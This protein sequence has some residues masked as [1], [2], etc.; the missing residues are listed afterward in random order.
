MPLPTD[1]QP[2]LPQLTGGQ[3]LPDVGLPQATD[4]QPELRQLTDGVREESVQTIQLEDDKTD[5][6]D[7][8]HSDLI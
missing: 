8:A 4:G 7:P 5:D 2:E 3:I 6:S 1:D